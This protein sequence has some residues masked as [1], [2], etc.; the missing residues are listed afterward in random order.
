MLENFYK[1]VENSETP[2]FSTPRKKRKRSTPADY[3]PPVLSASIRRREGLFENLSRTTHKIRCSARQYRTTRSQ[4][5]REDN[6]DD[7]NNTIAI[8]I[9]TFSGVLVSPSHTGSILLA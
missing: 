8:V 7:N 1:I 3:M 9:I 4:I 6:D 5:F 2:G